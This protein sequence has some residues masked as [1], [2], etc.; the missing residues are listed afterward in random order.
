MCSKGVIQ[1]DCENSSGNNNEGV[2]A[3]GER[4]RAPVELILMSDLRD[5][6]RLELCLEDT[7]G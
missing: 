5:G 7:S 6:S 4:Q 2:S 1:M 3:Q